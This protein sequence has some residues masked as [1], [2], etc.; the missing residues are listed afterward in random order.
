MEGGGRPNMPSRGLAPTPPSDLGSRRFGREDD[1]VPRLRVEQPAHQAG[2]GWKRASSK[3]VNELTLLRGLV[4]HW[5]E[6][7][8]A[9]LDSKR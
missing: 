8:R 2:G 9:R 3:A 5:E 1:G 6:A 4:P 7:M